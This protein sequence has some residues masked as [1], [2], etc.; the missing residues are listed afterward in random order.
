[1]NEFLPYIIDAGVIFVFVLYLARG[2]RKGLARTLV[3]MLS[4][5]FAMLLAWQL[6]EYVADFLR[7][8]GVQDKIAAGFG[9]SSQAPIEPGLTEATS[10]IENL[11]LPE[12]LKNSMIGN[13][14]YEAYAALGVKTFGDYIGVFLANIVVNAIALLGVFLIAFL[15]LRL[16]G[17]SLSLVNHIPLL[18]LANRSLGMIAN[19]IIGYFVI[20][21]VMFVFT[22]M[23]TG[24][25]FFAGVVLGIENS[26]V[27]VWF[28]HTNYLVD[29]IMK[30][31]A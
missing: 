22:M 3:T 21:L 4:C 20:Q 2:W 16:V 18:G 10:Y 14:N 12:A 19:G 24:Q 8:I 23:A 11:F 5:V 17:R 25:N 31:F 9:V 28:Y 29:W 1:M 26:T 6:Y 7:A 15:G 30:I 27:A 13:N